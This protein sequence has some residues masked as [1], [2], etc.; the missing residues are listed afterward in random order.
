MRVVRALR[1]SIDHVR[2]G[3][4]PRAQGS[5]VGDIDVAGSPPKPTS[6]NV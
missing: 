6:D 4:R 1:Y 5:L 3:K 2:A